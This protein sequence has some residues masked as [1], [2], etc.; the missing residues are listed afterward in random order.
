M[1]RA[2]GASLVG[3]DL[4]GVAV[5]QAPRRIK[6]FGVEGRARFEV[7]DLSALRFADCTF[8][9]AMSV[10]VLWMVPDTLAALRE[11]ARVVRPGARF[12]FANWDRDL[13]PPGWPPPVKDHRPLLGETGF[14]IAAGFV[15]EISNEHT[16]LPG[17]VRVR[18]GS[19]PACPAASYG[20]RWH[21]AP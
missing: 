20:S 3:V 13:S 15:A 21:S 8:D 9:A 7:G 6:E 1:A 18:P 12:V 5:G 17:S 11:V 16:L 14:V 2:T 19:C 4:S 10:D